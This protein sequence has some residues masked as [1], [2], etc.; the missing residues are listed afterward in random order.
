MSLGARHGLYEKAKPDCCPL[1]LIKLFDP[2]QRTDSAGMIALSFWLEMYV[3]FAIGTK[4]PQIDTLRV[5]A[6]AELIGNPLPKIVAS[7]FPKIPVCAGE[8]LVTI[9][10]IVSG[11]TVV[12]SA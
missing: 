10:G 3:T 4:F 12:E 8:K 5:L 6:E 9:S 2:L 7:T 11:V 1:Y